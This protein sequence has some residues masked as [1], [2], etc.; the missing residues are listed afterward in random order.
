VIAEGSDSFVLSNP[1]KLWVRSQSD[2][3]DNNFFD[4][5]GSIPVKTITP[6]GDVHHFPFGL[7]QAMLFTKATNDYL[8]LTDSNDWDFGAG[9]FTIDCWVNFTS[10]PST[11]TGYMGI[12]STF[13]Y[14][15]TDGYMLCIFKNTIQ[16]YSPKTGWVNTGVVAAIDTWYHIAAVRNGNTLTI[17]VNGVAAPTAIKTVTGMSFNSSNK[18]L[19]IGRD[20]TTRNID[21]LDGY[22]DEVRFMSIAI[23]IDPA[24]LPNDPRYYLP[25]TSVYIDNDSSWTYTKDDTVWG[26]DIQGAITSAPSKPIGLVN[27]TYILSGTLHVSQPVTIF[28]ESQAGVIIDASGNG[29]GYGIQVEANNVTLKNF[30]VLPPVVTS[31]GSVVTGALGGGFPIHTNPGISTLALE[32]FR[33][34]FDTGTGKY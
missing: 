23:D 33:S 20:D 10:V 32:N 13:N 14:P 6:N 5:S 34:N 26:T 19:V 27:D 24:N 28:G 25:A 9:N 17:Y 2:D 16:W 30:T 8:R 3:T 11:Y 31:G 4:D 7:D 21:Y 22:L 29:T 18:G 1:K 15:S 12:L